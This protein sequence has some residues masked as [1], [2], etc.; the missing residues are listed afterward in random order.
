MM[1]EFPQGKTKRDKRL[2]Q[3]RKRKDALAFKGFRTVSDGMMHA[4]KGKNDAR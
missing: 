2:K 3:L 4:P 1:L